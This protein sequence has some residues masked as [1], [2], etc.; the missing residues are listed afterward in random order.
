MLMAFT[1]SWF[2]KAVVLFVIG[3]IADRHKVHDVAVS[4]P[5]CDMAM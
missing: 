2:V 1:V 5:L 3:R 4:I